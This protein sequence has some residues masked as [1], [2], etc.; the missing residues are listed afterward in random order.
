MRRG[1]RAETQM[2][3]MRHVF[4]VFTATFNRARVLH[5]VYDSL[6]AQTFRD[7]EWLVVDDGS[8]DGTG[9]LVA[10]WRAEADFP[11]RY[12]YQENRGKHVACNRAVA[13]A[14]GRFFLTLDS[15]DAC[16]PQALARLNRHWEEIPEREQPGFSAVTVLCMDV[17]GRIVGDRF[18]P[19][20]HRLRPARGAVP[21]EGE[22]GEVGISARSMMIQPDSHRHRLRGVKAGHGS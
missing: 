3:Q 19:A 17:A 13:E 18:P 16:V 1:R 2:Q 20:H 11:I 7:F 22:R 15:D 8:T 4:T 9:A 5:R 21:P 14:R 10:A 6:R 12:R